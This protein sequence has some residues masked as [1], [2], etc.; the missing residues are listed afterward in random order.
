MTTARCKL[1]RV[2]PA[3]FN[4]LSENLKLFIMY[5]ITIAAVLF[6]IGSCS[7]EIHVY[8]DY[9]PDYDLK[10]YTT[11]GWKQTEDIELGNNPLYYNELND[12]RIKS[13]VQAQLIS[14]GY[15]ASMSNPDLIVHYHIIVDDQSIVTT[16][17]HGYF[18]SPYWMHLRT[19]VQHYRE[20]TLI[21][22]V[23]DPKNN[24]LIWRGWAASA[25]EGVYTPERIDHLIKTAV[26]KIFKRF[27]KRE[28]SSLPHDDKVVL[29]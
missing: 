26:A 14:K 11:F 12:K 10:K 16:D 5:K 20:G 1:V 9:D 27:P 3:N 23:M 25:I 21:I 18:Y 15:S 28:I 7:P 6:I 8:S 13:A 29:N 17:P 4:F 19:N 2:F 24:Y 22:D